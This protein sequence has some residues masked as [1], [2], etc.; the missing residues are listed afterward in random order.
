M[1]RNEDKTRVIADQGIINGN[2]Y[3][4]LLLVVLVGIILATKFLVF[5]N[6][7]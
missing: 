2:K 3:V 1:N 5:K 6:Y 7:D 4:G